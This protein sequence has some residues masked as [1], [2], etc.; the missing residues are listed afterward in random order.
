MYYTVKL[1]DFGTSKLRG[2][3]DSYFHT[4]TGTTSYMAPELSAKKPYTWSADVWSFGM[5]CY[6]IFTGKDPFEQVFRNEVLASGPSFLV[7]FA[8]AHRKVLG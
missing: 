8:E 5:T 3:E 6:K 2:T 1:I 4:K 7:P